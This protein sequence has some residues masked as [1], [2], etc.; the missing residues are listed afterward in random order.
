VTFPIDT[1]SDKSG[2]LSVLEFTN[3]EFPFF[4]KRLFYI[5]NVISG[6]TR[7]NHAHR[8]CHQVLVCFS[9]SVIVNFENNRGSFTQSL[10]DSSKGLH[11]PPMTWC[12]LSR[13]SEGAVLGVLASEV[14]E[15]EDYISDYSEFLKLLGKS[16]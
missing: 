7:G 2:V 9:G 14:Y 16:K 10:N 13:F 12:T 5:H 8:K 4:P 3:M 11:L 15:K 1:Y 6:A